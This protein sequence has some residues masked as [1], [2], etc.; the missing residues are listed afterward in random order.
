MAPINVMAR[1]TEPTAVSVPQDAAEHRY[2][3]SY[4]DTDAGGVLHHAKY[5]ELAETGRHW[6]LKHHGLS[7]RGLTQSYN[8]SFVVHQLDVRYQASIVLE[9]ELDIQTLLCCIDHAGLRWQTRIYRQQQCCAV[10]QTEMVCV[11]SVHKSLQRVPAALI[12][13][14][15]PAVATSTARSMLRTSRRI[16]AATMRAATQAS[17]DSNPASVTEVGATAMT[18][19]SQ[20]GTE[21]S[22]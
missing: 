16:R 19:S 11:N 5:I 4:A 10:I 2:L 15:T 3:V 1:P 22:L 6:W 12:Q 21:Y 8:A 18:A 17:P 20:R 13:Q 7:F 9:D 14:L